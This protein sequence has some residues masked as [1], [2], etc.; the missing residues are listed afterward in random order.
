MK[1]EK[2]LKKKHK[3]YSVEGTRMLSSMTNGKIIIYDSKGEEILTVDVNK[4]VSPDSLRGVAMRPN[5]STKERKALKL[6]AWLLETQRLKENE[7]V[8]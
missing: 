5:L 2:L 7:K 6:V 8:E 1:I 3:E 4:G